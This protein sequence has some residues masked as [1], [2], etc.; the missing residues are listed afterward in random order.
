VGS[1]DFVDGAY[2]GS[3]AAETANNAA[4]G[5]AYMPM[6]TL[7]MPGDAVTT[8]MIGALFTHGIQPGLLMMVLVYGRPPGTCQYFRADIRS[9]PISL[10]LTL[11]I[12]M[13]I[14]LQCQKVWF[15]KSVCT[16]I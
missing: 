8:I 1:G 2:E 4:V 12:V 11:G 9:H 14:L 5:G 7:G 10:V 6:L 16:G 3:I 13:L 15:S